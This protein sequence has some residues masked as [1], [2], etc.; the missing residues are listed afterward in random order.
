MIPVGFAWACGIYFNNN[1][2]EGRPKVAMQYYNVAL[3]FAVMV[4]II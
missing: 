4:T 1:L 3:V 2:G